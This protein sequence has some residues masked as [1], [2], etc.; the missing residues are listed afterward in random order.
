MNLLWIPNRIAA[1]TAAGASQIY[2]K[3]QYR[4]GVSYDV[5]VIGAGVVGC[6]A[7]YLLKSAGKR[8]ALIEGRTVG[9]GATANSTAEVTS[10]QGQVYSLI[11]TKH[12]R[13]YARL[14]YDMNQQAIQ[15]TKNLIRDQKLD[16]DLED[17]AHIL[18]TSNPAGHSIIRNE[19]DLCQR[20]FIDC[21]LKDQQSLIQEMPESLH[22]QI[23]LEF[24]DQ[25][26][27]NPYK[28]CTEL[29]RIMATN[30]SKKYPVL[31]KMIY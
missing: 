11:A 20:L 9:T 5:A 1:T 13:N 19:Y 8:V 6:T 24:P 25:A 4:H 7:A 31:L 10:L 14:Y 3:Y 30:T 17:R 12:D 16:C 15:F 21:K 18:W 29:C 2:P 27:F 28:Y 26:Q 22:P 23:G